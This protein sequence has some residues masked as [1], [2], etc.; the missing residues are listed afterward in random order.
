MLTLMGIEAQWGKVLWFGNRHLRAVM[1][2][3]L[4]APRRCVIA[5]R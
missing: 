1:T 2:I 3:S 5:T 4:A